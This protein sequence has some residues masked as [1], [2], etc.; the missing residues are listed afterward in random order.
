MMVWDEVKEGEEYD[1]K[2]EDV[3]KEGDGI[4][5]I[6]HFVVFI[7]GAEVGERVK[8]KITKKLRTLAFGEVIKR[9][10]ETEEDEVS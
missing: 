4:A 9:L 3:G 2:I 5:K 8:I 6:N 1:V 7:P 10:D